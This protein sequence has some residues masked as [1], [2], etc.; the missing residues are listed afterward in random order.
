MGLGFRDL[1]LG[2]VD[3][4][5]GLKDLRFGDLG[6]G[7]PRSPRQPLGTSVS[8]PTGNGKKGIVDG[9]RCRI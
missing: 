3:L 5:S 2:F 4:G 9:L 8:K 1:G 6:F 7:L